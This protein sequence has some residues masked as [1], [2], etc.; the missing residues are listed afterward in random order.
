MFKTIDIKNK[1]YLFLP[2]SLS[3]FDFNSEILEIAKQIEDNEEIEN[4]NT[5]SIKKYL[6]KEEK[7]KEDI[8]DFIQR[9][10]DTE[11][12]ISGCEINVF[13]G[14]NLSCKYCFACD[15]GHGKQGAM[16][17]ET[18]KDVIDYVLNN[19]TDSKKI[20]VTIIGGEP[21]LNM[22]AFE[23]ILQYGQ[24]ESK[25]KNKK[26]HF[27]TTTN[28]TLINED[29]LDLF[30][31]NEVSCAI[32]LD[33]HIKEVND[34][35]RPSKNGKSTYDGIKNNWKGIVE[36]KH[37]SIHV[38][39]TP[40]NKNISEIA[41]KLFDQGIYH[42]HFFEVKTD[43]EEL[44]FTKEDIEDLKKEYEKL[45]DLILKKIEE[46]ENISCYPL[47]NYLNR[48]HNK[49]PVF[50]TCGTFNNR[51]SFSPE[52]DIYPCDML[53]WD[54]YHMGS[55]KEGIEQNKVLELKEILNNEKECEKCWARY[56]C[57]G[58]CLGDK[59]WENKKQRVLRCDLKKHVLS[60]KLYIY[61]YIIKNIKGFDF[62]KY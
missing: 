60:L 39:I 52:G 32:S 10:K 14:C 57:G 46:G 8:H 59:V 41:K 7:A 34:Y 21:L 15:G 48:L 29:I 4:E 5:I 38:A 37:S 24:N 20:K 62:S 28:G 26:M 22:P 51:I 61:D 6:E 35:L 45:A 49:K 50:L 43:N 44:Q 58:E 9:F 36:R 47:L 11:M 27:G 12:K 33:S 42:I 18:A 19:A 16:T 25:K 31:E 55:V 2:H 53:M 56:L 13:Y 23:E 30:K 1:K 40:C 54:K 3:L 17:K